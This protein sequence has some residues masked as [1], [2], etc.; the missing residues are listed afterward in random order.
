MSSKNIEK[1]EDFIFIIQNR[2]QT[3]S[4]H[5]STPEFK[6]NVTPNGSTFLQTQENSPE[7]ISLDKRIVSRLEKTNYY[8]DLL[9]NNH[10]TI[11][12]TLSIIQKNKPLYEGNIILSKE[13]QLGYQTSYSPDFNK[14][15]GN[16]VKFCEMVQKN[17]NEN[18]L[19]NNEIIRL[20][21]IKNIVEELNDIFYNCILLKDIFTKLDRIIQQS[22]NHDYEYDD[23]DIDLDRS[24]SIKY[25]NKCY[26]TVRY[27]SYVLHNWKSINI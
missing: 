14:I 8:C 11:P 24:M 4:S 20:M 5:S 19:S 6:R 15:H 12:D 26:Y 1:I 27:I 17:L 18:Y 21:K 13:Q 9:L 16:D 22:C 7:E 25:C 3:L 2:L 10:Q 23:I